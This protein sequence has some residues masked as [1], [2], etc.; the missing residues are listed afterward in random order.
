MIYATEILHKLIS[1]VLYTILNQLKNKL[2]AIVTVMDE[3]M[4]TKIFR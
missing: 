3:T 4:G 2:T 1:N